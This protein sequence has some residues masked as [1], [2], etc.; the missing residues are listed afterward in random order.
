MKRKIRAAIRN[1]H[2]SHN[3]RA[4][5][6]VLIDMWDGPG[7]AISP[8]RA[9]IARKSGLSVRTIARCLSDFRKTGFIVPLAPVCGP[10][11]MGITYEIRPQAIIGGRA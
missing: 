7:S 9:E 1:S 4:V 11:G 2:W 6:R 5:L 3:E 10:L 8:T